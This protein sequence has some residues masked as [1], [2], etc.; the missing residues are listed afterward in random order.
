MGFHGDL[1]DFSS[2][3]T[4]LIEVKQREMFIT[5][6]QEKLGE[7]AKL[8]TDFKIDNGKQKIYDVKAPEHVINKLREAGYIRD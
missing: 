7:E 3:A 1:K 2:K 6:F 4:S 5:Y 8:I